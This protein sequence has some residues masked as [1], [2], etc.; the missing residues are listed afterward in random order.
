MRRKLLVTPAALLAFAA[1][2]VLPAVASASPA[3]TSPLGTLAP[4]G[5]K[6][7]GT[8]IGATKMTLSN[9]ATLECT[10]GVN[11]GVL[12]KNTGTF[13]EGEIQTLEVSGTAAG[14][15]CTSSMGS[16][17]VTTTPGNGLPYCMKTA[18]TADQLE[19]RG[20]SCSSAARPITYLVDFTSLGVACDYERSTPILATFTTAPTDATATENEVLFKLAAGSSFVCPAEAKLDA[21]MT[22][23]NSSTG[24]AAYVS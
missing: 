1:F 4:V 10:A 15:D 6:F 5:T 8:T 2:I 20:G 21:S 24:A 22:L 13:I 12:L 9:G 3:L 18:K 19:I 7:K 23:E 16:F 11:S 14:G 17:K